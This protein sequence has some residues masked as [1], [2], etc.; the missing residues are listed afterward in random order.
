MGI[1]EVWLPLMD[2]F[3]RSSISDILWLKFS[4]IEV[5]NVTSGREE[6]GAEGALNVELAMGGPKETRVEDRLGLE[7]VGGFG[8]GALGGTGAVGTATG[9]AGGGSTKS[10]AAALISAGSIMS[11]GRPPLL[12]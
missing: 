7:T 2:I 12:G 9:A 4:V 6:M 8:V 3:T 1:K 10:E 5:N 11:V